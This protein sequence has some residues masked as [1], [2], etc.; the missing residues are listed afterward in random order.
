MCA[1]ASPALSSRPTCT[2][3]HSPAVGVP[4][5]HRLT[6]DP[7]G[8]PSL[9]ASHPHTTVQRPCRL[10]RWCP[11]AGRGR[12]LRSPRSLSHMYTHTYRHTHT[13][14]EAHAH[15]HAY[16]HMHTETRTRA[17]LLYATFG[18]DYEG[19]G[20]VYPLCLWVIDRRDSYVYM[21]EAVYEC[22]CA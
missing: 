10:Q 21:C 20:G 22:V 11:G 8:N 19:K 6:S 12:P 2:A 4:S 13:G 16:V 9:L 1:P 5:G 7:G 3:G 14:T 17:H 18:E 15:T